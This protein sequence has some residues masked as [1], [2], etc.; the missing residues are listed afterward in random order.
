[1][2]HLSSKKLEANSF[3]VE[4]VTRVGSVLKEEIS[5]Y[6]TKLLPVFIAKMNE[7]IP[8]ADGDAEENEVVEK[9]LKATE[10]LLETKS[11]ILKLFAYWLDQIPDKLM[12]HIT[13]ICAI[14]SIEMKSAFETQL[15]AIACLPPLYKIA[16][17]T[18]RQSTMGVEII[19]L[20][21]QGMQHND[22]DTISASFDCFDDILKIAPSNSFQSNLVGFASCID[23]ANKRVFNK[24]PSMLAIEI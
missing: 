15:H 16:Q 18:G 3:V 17:K 8:K 11:S 5:P 19:K 13:S 9:L 6:L 22:L 21:I 14:I 23:A 20:V 7:S 1:M 12:S 2:D 10:V 4:A 24:K